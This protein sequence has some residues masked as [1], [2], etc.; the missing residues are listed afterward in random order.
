MIAF[1]NMMAISYPSHRRSVQPKPKQLLCIYTRPVLILTDTHATFPM[2]VLAL[3]PR[4]LL[5]RN[6]CSGISF[7]SLRIYVSRNGNRSDY[8]HHEH[9]HHIQTGSVFSVYNM[10]CNMIFIFLRR[11]RMPDSPTSRMDGNK[12]FCTAASSSI[13]RCLLRLC[14]LSQR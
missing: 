11:N 3:P 4:R 10:V 7:A 1:A 13:R 2:V 14:I 6:N 12:F 5:K 9:E 8:V